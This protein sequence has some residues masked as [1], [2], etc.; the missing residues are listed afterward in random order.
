MGEKGKQ[1]RIRVTKVDGWSDIEY[2]GER[3]SMQKHRGNCKARKRVKKV[4]E[5]VSCGCRC[6]RVKCYYLR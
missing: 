6:T 4:P 2:Q 3:Y 5:K 1:E